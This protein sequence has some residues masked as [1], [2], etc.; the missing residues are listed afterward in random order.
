MNAQI[1]DDTIT[2]F[3]PTAVWHEENPSPALRTL[4]AVEWKIRAY[5]DELVESGQ[6]IPGNGR[7]PNLVGPRFGQV[8]LALM[9][10]DA[11]KARSAAA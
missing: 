11:R 2:D 8:L 6:F 3:K 4:G 5:F 7:S 9:R 10:R 1:D